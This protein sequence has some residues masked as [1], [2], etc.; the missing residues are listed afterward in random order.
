MRVLSCESS[1]DVT[2]YR[3]KQAVQTIKHP[4]SLWHVIALPN[5]D[6]VTACQDHGARIFT[7]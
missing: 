7:R 2:L 1:F 6:F 4:S 5:G 3:Y